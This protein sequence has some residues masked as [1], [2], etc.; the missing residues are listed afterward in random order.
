MENEWKLN[1]VYERSEL[2]YNII[3]LKAFIASDEFN[4][5]HH[6]ERESLWDQ[7]DIMKSYRK[8]LNKRIRRII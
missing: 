2:E 6:D 4:K 8:V 3:K 1:L 7:L 5:C